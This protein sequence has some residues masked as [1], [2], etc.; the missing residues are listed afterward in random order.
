M[1]NGKLYIL[2]YLSDY[3]AAKDLFSNTLPCAQEIYSSD[4]INC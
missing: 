3:V 2:A 1:N 4:L